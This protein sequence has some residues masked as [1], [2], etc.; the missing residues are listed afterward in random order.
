MAANVPVVRSKN[1]LR[2][3]EEL[4]GKPSAAGQARRCEALAEKAR[5]AFGGEPRFF[6]SPGRT[7]LG[8]NHTDHNRGR[9]LCAAVTLD[10]LAAVVPSEGKDVEVWSEGWDSPFRVDFSSLLPVEAERGTTEAL[11]RGVAEGFKEAGHAVGGFRAVV[12]SRVLPGSGLSSSAAME[13]LFGTILSELYNEG[14]VPALEIARIGQKAENRHFGKPCGLMDQTASAAGGVLVID[15][16]DPE[17]PRLRR[18]KA[19]FEKLGYVLAV[20][21]PGGDHAD[22]TEDYA[23]IPREMRAAASV[24]GKDTLRGLERDLFLRKLPEVRAAAGDRAALRVLHFLDE[25][26]RV[27]SMAKALEGRRAKRYLKLVRKSGLSSWR[28]L[29]NI[30]PPGDPRRQS[31]A[32]AL[33]LTESF[34]GKRGACRVHGGGFAGTMQAYVP[35]ER[36]KGYREYME[37]LFGPGCVVPL[38]VRNEGACEVKAAVS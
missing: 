33:A 12:D 17:K 34:L 18:L 35:L 26:E 13:V 22:L 28:L 21:T 2:R 1:F 38:R 3:L 19:D 6:S 8:G 15:F 23:D 9:V 5:A 4:Y 25:D 14:A 16:C 30:S 11:I 32:L 24:F 10:A 29:Q 31:L 20:I 7:E 36:L 37:R 27:L